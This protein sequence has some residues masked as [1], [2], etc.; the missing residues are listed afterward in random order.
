MWYVVKS[1]FKK[2]YFW[3][4][5]LLWGILFIQ[6]TSEILLPL[7]LNQLSDQ[8]NYYAHATQPDAIQSVVLRN[9]GILAGF[10]IF[11]SIVFLTCGVT[12]GSVSAY[13]A[14]RLSG[15]IRV[16]IYNKIQTLSFAEI[17]ALTTP[18]LITRITTDVDTIQNALFITFRVGFR[19]ILLFFGGLTGTIILSVIPNVVVLPLE[20][21]TGSVLPNTDPSGLWF[22]VPLL[23]F[24]I[25][26]GM[27]FSLFFIL[28]AASKRYRISKYAV[29]NSNDV[30][31]ENI[32]GVR[33]VKSFNLHEE[34]TK[35][36]AKANEKL[37]KTVEKS[38][39]ISMWMFPIIN[40]CMSWTT[41]LTIFVGSVSGAITFAKVGSIMAIT[42]LLLF[43]MT[44]AINVVLQLSIAIGSAPRI[45]EVLKFKPNITYK[46]NGFEIEKP[47][48][49]F[50]KVN[51]RYNDSGEYVLKNINLTI[52]EDE[53]VGIIGAT[54]SGKSTF[55]SLIT[56]MYDVKEGS[57]EI[58][59]HNVKDIKRE[60][61][62]HEIAV[63]PQRVTLFS[64]TI[65]SNLKYGKDNATE[66]DM[67]DAAKGSQAYEFIMQKDGKFDC[68]V[69]QR[70]RNFSG[71][72]QQRLSIARAL[73]GK[74]KI[75]IL[76]SSTSAL[77]MIT[78]RKVNEYIKKTNVGRTTFII[79]Q[80]ISGVKQADR[81]L[82]FDKGKIVG[83][84]SHINL[85]KNNSVYRDIAIS[86]LGEEGVNEELLIK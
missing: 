11:L 53:T 56:R 28:R 83:D 10:M 23:L 6:V 17:D 65:A 75:L 77:D 47:T 48:I 80:R 62:R 26:L 45:V 55:I 2:K 61:L 15:D 1:V 67:I 24:V 43:G 20:I 72:Q 19:S 8:A 68:K 70:G 22:L 71:G 58:S 63:S 29:D 12:G 79:S 42:T 82:V 3:F 25:S 14:S 86:Q 7:S 54:G 81:I 34:Q 40:V 16:K 4:L 5:L 57:V 35:R 69:E 49:K 59:G 18:S 44:L 52:K 30:M 78:E 74:P 46:E 33:L 50:N 60:S 36:F 39:L 37:R 21:P 85:L 84:D 73:I 64:G 9:V 31:R 51:F 76:D 27:F 13:L 38:F 41:I 66:A 32:L